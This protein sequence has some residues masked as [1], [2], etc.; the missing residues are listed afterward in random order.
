MHKKSIP[1]VKENI[2]ICIIRIFTTKIARNYS[3]S[4]EMSKKTSTISVAFWV[5]VALLALSTFVAQYYAFTNPVQYWFYFGWIAWWQMYSIIWY[6]VAAVIYVVHLKYWR[7][8]KPSG[9]KESGG[10]E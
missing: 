8:S 9:G 4:L 6:S 3:V 1:L 7:P 5:V 10:A 2:W